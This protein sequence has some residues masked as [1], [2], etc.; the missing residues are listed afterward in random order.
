MK[1][2]G[3]ARIAGVFG[4]PIS[5]SR[6]PQLHKYWLDRY[7]I[8]GAYV[9]LAV[10]PEDFPTA[11]R[12]APRLGLV[13]GNVTVPHKEAAFAACDH[14]DATA[15]RIG[16]VNTLIFEPTGGITGRN[17]DAYGFLEN[18]RHG[19]PAWR[20]DAGPAVVLG[21]GG[22]ARA[23]VVALLDAGAPELRLVNRTAARAAAL[24]E[25]FGRR[26]RVVPWDGFAGAAD[27]AALLVNTTTQGMVGEPPLDLALVSLPVTATVTDL[28]Y[29]PLE[30]KLLDDARRRGHPVVDG[31]G[32]LLWQAKPGFAAW[33]GV[34]PEVTE[35][36][37]AAVLTDGAP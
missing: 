16:A 30:T 27:Q 4:W 9:P 10:R 11:V 7:G 1:P 36:L 5:H 6:S 33:F 18:V 13:G 28:V 29:T 8:D 14:V 3:A 17:T 15:K 31:L 12:A 21:A 2:T 25:E 37:R 20:A 23:V 24:A 19:A 32:M 35:A 26:V 34:D 22:S